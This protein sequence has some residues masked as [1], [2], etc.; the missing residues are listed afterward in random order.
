MP[1]LSQS[2]EDE[3]EVIKHARVLCSLL[4]M[5]RLFTGNDGR[6]RPLIL[7]PAARFQK[8]NGRRSSLE[9]AIHQFYEEHALKKERNIRENMCVSALWF[10]LCVRGRHDHI[11]AGKQRRNSSS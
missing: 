10:S 3:R 1:I 7:R 8:R 9:C 4:H 11:Y 5:P 2:L 6:S